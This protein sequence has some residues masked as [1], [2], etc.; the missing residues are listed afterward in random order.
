MSRSVVDVLESG[1][2]CLGL[3]VVCDGFAHGY[4]FRVQTHVHE[5]HMGDF[6]KSK[7]YQD[8]FM[9]PGTY[10]LLVA[11]RNAELEYRSNLYQVIHGNDRV[12]D[13]GS[14]LS[15]ISSNHMLGACQVVLELPSGLRIGYS[16]DFGWPMDEVIQ[17]D[18]LVVDS[19]YGSPNSVRGYTQAEA[20][21]RLLEI[22][23]SRL[24]HGPVHIQAYRGTIERALQVISGNVGAPIV[25]T[26]RRIQEIN[27]YQNHGLATEEVFSVNSDEGKRALAERS[28]VRLY[29]KGDELKNEPARGTKI[30]CSAFMVDRDTPVKQFSDGNYSVALTNHADF[31]ETLEYIAATGAKTVVTDNTRNHGVELAMAI[32]ARFPDVL[33]IPSSNRPMP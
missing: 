13:D 2:V 24:R 11:D 22:V 27:V 20:E 23:S 8:L 3:N 14:A 4:P 21:E 28:Y 9:S 29:A 31:H 32:K 16:G 19:T 33:A 17:V 18:Q 5:D 25:A 10:E 12:L 26:E 7:G 6:D 30:K 1:A 15:L